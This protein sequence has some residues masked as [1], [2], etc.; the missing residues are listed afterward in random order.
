V[1]VSGLSRVPSSSHA[2]DA[3]ALIEAG[4]REGLSDRSLVAVLRATGLKRRDAYRRVEAA[5]AE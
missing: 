1:V 5:R 4:R 2:V 3:D